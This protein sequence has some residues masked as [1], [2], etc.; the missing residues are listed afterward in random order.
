MTEI[1]SS[2]ASQPSL[3]LRLAGRRW[4][5]TRYFTGRLALWRSVTALI[6]AAPAP[7]L[8]CLD[9]G[10]GDRPLDRAL[11]ARGWHSVGIDL[12]NQRANVLARVERL[13]IKDQ[14]FDLVTCLSVLQYVD[15]PHNACHELNRVLRADGSL[16][17][18]LPFAALL[19]PLDVWRWSEQ[20]A[21]R[22]LAKAG[23]IDIEVR[24]IAPTLTVVFHLLGLGIGKKIPIVGRILALPF[25][26]IAIASLRSKDFSLAGGY[27]IRGTK[28]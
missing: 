24:P 28:P 15:E 14:S 1:R 17:V 27:A 7:G 23:F 6:P 5:R 22:L 8:D 12:T 25:E 3:P 2:A 20:A 16:I 10:C 11:E 13:P 18:V 19:D 4:L 9:V 26:L 21:I